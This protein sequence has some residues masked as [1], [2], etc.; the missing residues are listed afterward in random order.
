MTSTKDISWDD[1][2][3]PFQLKRSGVRGRATRL[4]PLLEHVLSR[5]DYPVAVSAMVAELVTLTAL[6]GPT[7][8][9]RWKLSLQV[10]G[11]GAIRTI[12]TDYYA[13]ET[14]GAPARI[15]AWAS[16]D[17]AR[18]DDRPAFQQIGDGYFAVLIDQ[19]EG[20]TP[21]QGLTPLAGGSLA[22]C[23]QNY[24]AQ[25]EQLPTKFEL[26]VGRSRLAG[27]TAE[28]WRAG[29]VML[30]TLPA[31]PQ[32]VTENGQIEAADILQGAESEDWNRATMLMS[33]VE[34]IELVDASLP[35]P[36]LVFRL[37]HEEEPTAFDRQ[38]MQFGCSCSAEKVRGT[39]S[40]Y[41]QKDIGHM[42]NDDGIVTADCQFCGAH[43]E[44]DPR[45]LGFEAVVDE[46]GNPLPPAEAAQ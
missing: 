29:G 19:G 38:T 33:T 14:E 5:H 16:F 27:D 41:S 1:S 34:A 10:R 46:H 22:S 43:Y 26:T 25:S 30:Q 45:S 3:L 23:A 32:V 6:I 24:F 18:L 8:K 31:Q 15:R 39:L 36:N 42:T 21:Y 4:G 28:H 12:A 37:F 20:N 13:P 9:L 17:A 35:L 44:F 7:I 11:S 2:V 40:I